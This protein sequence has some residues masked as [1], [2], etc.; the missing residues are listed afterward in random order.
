MSRPV[1]KPPTPRERQHIFDFLAREYYLCHLVLVEACI[2]IVSNC[3]NYL[4]VVAFL[5]LPLRSPYISLLSI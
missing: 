5:V 2:A 3:P 4:Q 1:R